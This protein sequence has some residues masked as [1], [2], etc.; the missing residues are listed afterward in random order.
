MH[1]ALQAGSKPPCAA[2]KHQD[3][4]AEGPQ[5]LAA[6]RGSWRL[7]INALLNIQKLRKTRLTCQWRLC[8]MVTVHHLML[9]QPGSW[10]SLIMLSHC[11]RR[12][13]VIDYPL[14]IKANTM[15]VIWSHTA[16]HHTCC[17]YNHTRHGRPTPINLHTSQH[18]C[19]QP[20]PACDMPCGGCT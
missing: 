15:G 18:G 3:T 12:P 4:Y 11:D 9:T 6:L 13:A 10:P 5:Q 7:C 16:V 2:S 1:I 8:A 17:I 20:K 14:L 19:T